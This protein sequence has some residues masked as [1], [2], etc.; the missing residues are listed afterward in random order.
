MPDRALPVTAE[1]TRLYLQRAVAVTA[2]GSLAAVLWAAGSYLTARPSLEVHLHQAAPPSAEAPEQA[3]IRFMEILQSNPEDTAA[4]SALAQHFADRGE[5][6]RAILFAQRAA[7]ADPDD[8]GLL[9][10]LGVM[11]HRAGRN[12]EAAASLEKALALHENPSIRYSLGILYRDYLDNP[13]KGVALLRQVLDDPS[14]PQA[15]KQ[16]AAQALANAE[17]N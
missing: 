16:H 4:L 13:E 2:A 8:P 7:A 11:Q 14:A 17:K 10:R 12:A 1:R 3:A 15:L 5:P 9:H 6:E